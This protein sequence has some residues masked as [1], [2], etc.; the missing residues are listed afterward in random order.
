LGSRI[1]PPS[2]ERREIRDGDRLA[3]VTAVGATLSSFSM[4]GVEVADGF[5]VGEMWS[6]GRAHC[7]SAQG[8]GQPGV[9]I[10]SQL[11]VGLVD[12]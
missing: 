4:A 1:R 12:R 3:V 9:L 2:G 8:T 7:A 6:A 5:D 11:L 10:P